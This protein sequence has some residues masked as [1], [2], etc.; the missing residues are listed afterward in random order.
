MSKQIAGIIVS[1]SQL[2]QIRGKYT[3]LVSSVPSQLKTPIGTGVPSDIRRFRRNEGHQGVCL[4]QAM[5]EEPARWYSGE[6]GR[7]TR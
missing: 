4:S 3:Q 6:G 2:Y 1:G 5:L 7:R